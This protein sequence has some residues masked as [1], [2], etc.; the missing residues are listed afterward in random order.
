MKLTVG[1]Q[2]RSARESRGL[3][4]EDAVKATNIRRA[5]LQE[6]ENDHPELLHSDAQARGFLRLYASYLGLPAAPL[7]AAWDNPTEFAAEEKEPLDARADGADD[8][9]P[10]DAG[11]GSEGAEAE[12]GEDVQPG[13]RQDAPSDEAESP[14]EEGQELGRGDQNQAGMLARI[15]AAL[16]RIPKITQLLPKK[17]KQ[18]SQKRQQR[19]AREERTPIEEPELP[20]IT[21]SSQEIL[22]DIGKT[23]RERRDA[24]ELTLG[25]AETFT[26][27]KRMYLEAMEAGAFERMPSTVQ[28]RGMLNNYAHFLGV[29]ETWI[30]DAYAKALQSVRAE[31]EALRPP[32]PAP[33]LTVRL[34]I[35]EKW[36]RIL[37]PDLILGGLFIIALF[38][39]IIW[40]GAQVFSAA[41]PE[42][43]DAPSISE[44]LAQTPTPTPVVAE[45]TAVNGDEEA[46]ETA[47]PGVTVAEETPVPE[48]T[49][50]PA[51]LQ[52]YIIVS[53]RAFLRITEDGELEFNG[54]VA[55]GDVFTF[56]AEEEITLLT[57]NG[58]ALEVYFNQEYLG[59]LGT[60]G[61]VVSLTFSLDGLRETAPEP[62]ATPENAQ[63]PLEEDAM[64]MTG[65][66]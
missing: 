8:G 30:M 11:D 37:N 2:L 7:I 17:D 29:D 59:S 48:V 62:E 23:L 21:R 13:E 52:V 65:D 58:A 44:V 3:T 24:L 16:Q 41:E 60:V 20:V 40:G 1:E 32:K 25:D 50:N 34:N 46:Q 49:V 38:A 12:D 18:P 64:E 55:A 54:R 56:S 26:N 35:P 15:R 31:K 53:D 5:Y 63:P 43:T 10:A 28:G 14:V 42:S 9:T 22:V 66:S 36:R 47:I 4:I 39:F 6:L 61:E 33:P 27:V 57:G 51:P 19:A 45:S